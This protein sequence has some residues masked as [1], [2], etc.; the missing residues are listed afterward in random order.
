M[1]RIPQL[2]FTVEFYGGQIWLMTVFSIIYV[3]NVQHCSHI[4]NAITQVSPQNGTHLI[5]L[6]GEITF[7][8]ISHPEWQIKTCYI[9]N[10]LNLPFKKLLKH[11]HDMHS[12]NVRV[13][14]RGRSLHDICKPI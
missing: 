9:C 5:F 8:N 6:K 2:Y 4:N 11:H 3:F 1:Y 7:I 14:Y 13:I 10:Y 12:K